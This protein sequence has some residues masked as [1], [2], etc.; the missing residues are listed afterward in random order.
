MAQSKIDPANFFSILPGPF[1]ESEWGNRGQK[2]LRLPQPNGLNTHFFTER[3]HYE[4][5]KFNVMKLHE[6][7]LN[8]I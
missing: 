6:I 4:K 2:W 5:D 1:F 3:R 8:S 7:K